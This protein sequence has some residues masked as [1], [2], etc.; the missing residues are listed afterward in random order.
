MNMIKLK[1][2]LK[3]SPWFLLMIFYVLFLIFSIF[4]ITVLIQRCSNIIQT[5][6]VKIHLEKIWYGTN[7]TVR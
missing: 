5:D 2:I 3:S 7:N 6:G 1:A 4:I